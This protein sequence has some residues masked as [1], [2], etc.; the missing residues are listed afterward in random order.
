MNAG[1]EAVPLG[2]DYEATQARRRA[3]GHQVDEHDEH[4]GSPRSSRATRPE[5]SSS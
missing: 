3:A 4:W 1:H 5:T 2:D